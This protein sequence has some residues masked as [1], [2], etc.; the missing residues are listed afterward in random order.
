VLATYLARGALERADSAAYK[1]RIAVATAW[2]TQVDPKHPLD[3]GAHYLATRDRASL[4]K[5]FQMQLADGSWVHEPF[6]TAIALL[7]LGEAQSKARPIPEISDR[8]ARARTWLLK[9][10]FPEGGWPGTTRPAG[11]ASYAQHIS[12]TAWTAIALAVT[13]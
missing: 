2:L 13:K 12:T 3:A 9:T 1:K 11:G 6:D 5:L 7:A 4:E 8:I 10:Q